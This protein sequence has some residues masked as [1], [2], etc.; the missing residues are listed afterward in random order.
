VDARTIAPRTSFLHRLQRSR[1]GLLLG[2]ERKVVLV[3][4]LHFLLR[5]LERLGFAGCAHKKILKTGAQRM[6][7]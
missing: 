4:L 7:I 2:L 1:V 6:E 5:L 3:Q